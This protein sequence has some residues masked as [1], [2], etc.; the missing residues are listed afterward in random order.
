MAVVMFS[1][2]VLRVREKYVKYS[3]RETLRK[4]NKR[5][6]L[7]TDGRITLKYFSNK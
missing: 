7:G 4:K 6:N 3:G 1:N 2:S 5:E